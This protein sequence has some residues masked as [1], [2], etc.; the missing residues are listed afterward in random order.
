MSSSGYSFYTSGLPRQPGEPKWKYFIRKLFTTKS[1][2]SLEEDQESS[3]LK[4][5]LG[6]LDFVM[7]GIGNVIGSGIFVL[8]GEAA[9]TK[10]GPA[11]VISFI[12]SGIASSFA[13]L[14][15]SELSTMIPVS[16]SAYTYSYA[17]MGEL[18]GWII[19][20]DLI[21]EYLVA[22]AAVAVGWSEYFVHFFSDTFGIEFGSSWTKAPFAFN[23]TTASFESVPGAYFNVPAFAITIILTIILIIGIRESATVNTIIV[24]IKVFVIVIFVIAA[25]TKINPENYKPFVPP[26]E[27]TFSAF[28]VTGIFA[29]ASEVFFAYIGFDAVSTTA[30]EARNPQRDLPIGII[31]SLGICTV[32]Y[33]AV[34]VVL[35]G[36]V[37]YHELNSAAPIAVAVKSIN[38]KWLGVIVNLGAI[39]GL[40]SVILVSLMGQPRIFYSMA[41]DGLFLPKTASK[42][43]PKFQTP[44]ITT[45]IT[46]SICAVASAI[47]P[48]DVLANLT[49]VGTLLAFFL[50]NISVMILRLTAPDIPRK[51]K[52]PGGP[53]VVPI[54]GAA[55]SLLLLATATKS[56]I[57]R[58]FI[59]MAIGLVI[60]FSYGRRHSKAN[61]P[62]KVKQI[63]KRGGIAEIVELE[64]KKEGEI[65]EV[66]VT[67][68]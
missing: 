56:S 32:L 28:G 25:S 54:I 61:N 66:E 8:T 57:E 42:V 55:L 63:E 18:I 60:Y 26:N 30:Q 9:A 37:P 52:V 41:Q 21:L 11:I 2:N 22:A 68:I 7:L 20:W 51:F 15:Y 39:A 5:S 44:Y 58:L 38:M 19:G 46:G 4:R 36:I 45:A 14:S 40:T 33:I 34:C 27:G 1:I 35:T 59:W 12:I 3:R 53:F 65:D 43:H 17:T 50:V 62:D 23:E 48:I 24:G 49:S 29:A 67:E 6:A 64:K 13:A 16:G 10:S 47:L 31:G